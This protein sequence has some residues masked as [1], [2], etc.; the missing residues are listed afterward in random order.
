MA[1][2]FNV[3]NFLRG[4]TPEDVEAEQ[5]LNDLQSSM[6]D[7]SPEQLEEV[8]EVILIEELEKIEDMV[9]T[10]ILTAIH[11]KM[12]LNTIDDFKAVAKRVEK[13]IAFSPEY[14]SKDKAIKEHLQTYLKNGMELIIASFNSHKF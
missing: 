2:E 11:A 1:V 3:F 4:D 9:N 14:K 10:F 6:A 5:A 12:G 7:L 8:Q 13:K